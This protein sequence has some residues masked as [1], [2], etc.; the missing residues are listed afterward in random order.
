MSPVT[1]LRIQCD[2]CQ[3]VHMFSMVLE[4]LVGS[5]E[6]DMGSEL[7]YRAAADAKCECGNVIEYERLRWEYPPGMDNYEEMDVTGGQ[8]V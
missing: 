4:E 5:N 6:R 8:V 7:T 2:K 1:G 3:R